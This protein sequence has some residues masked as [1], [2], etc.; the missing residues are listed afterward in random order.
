MPEVSS[1]RSDPQY[2]NKRK[3]LEGHSLGQRMRRK[4]S[5]FSG[6][7]KLKLLG[8]D[9]K[10]RS[11]RSGKEDRLSAKKLVGIYIVFLMYNLL[12]IIM[13]NDSDALEPI[14]KVGAILTLDFLIN[15]PIPASGSGSY[16][17]GNS[18]TFFFITCG[19]L[20]SIDK[21]R[22]KVFSRW[23]GQVFFYLGVFT[24]VYLLASIVHTN[25]IY[26]IPFLLIL[27]TLW[28]IFQS[29][30]YYTS[31]RGFSTKIET[32]LV[33]RYSKFR[34]FLAFL[35]PMI[36]VGIILFMS[37]SYRFGWV[38]LALDITSTINPSQSVEFYRLLMNRVIPA[39]YIIVILITLFLVLVFILS[40]KRAETRSTGIWDN[41]T[42]A[43]MSFFLFIWMIFMVTVYLLL[44]PQSQGLWK[45]LFL[46][47]EGETGNTGFAI[48]LVEFAVSMVFL[49]WIIKDIGKTF[50]WRVF[51]LQKDGL[52]F[53]LLAIIMGQSVSRYAIINQIEPEYTGV[54]IID[55]I[56]GYDRLIIP[57]FLIILLGITVLIYYL[58]PQ[59]MSMFMRREKEAVEEE[60]R[61]M[62]LVLKFLRREFIRKGKKFRV[63]SID[64]RLSELLNLPLSVVHSLITRITGEY[65]DIILEEETTEEGRV[66]YIDFVPITERYQDSEQAEKKA[67][68]L[69]TQQLAG[70]LQAKSGERQKILVK[71]RKDVG[72]QKDAR[73]SGLISGLQ[74][75][76][77]RQA[78]QR[79]EMVRS[80]KTVD[81][82]KD[83]KEDIPEILFT[84][85]R[86]E[87]IYRVK[88]HAM[89]PTP[90][91][92]ILDI[93]S[94]VEEITRIN[95]A[96]LQAT[97]EVLTLQNP[98]IVLV[99]NPTEPENKI[100]E[101]HPI[102]DLEL[103]DIIEEFYPELLQQVRHH[104]WNAL[105]VAVHVKRN[106][107]LEPIEK[108]EEPYNPAIKQLLRNLQQMW[109][110]LKHPRFTK[111]DMGK[112]YTIV[113]KL[114]PK[115]ATGWKEYVATGRA[116]IEPESSVSQK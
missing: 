3:R 57:M 2:R 61:A 73:A 13:A 104:L 24:G 40:M 46:S 93:A 98:N 41:F 42:F 76:F 89:F 39:L 26:M 82:R 7:A 111:P 45:S 86:N 50:G 1:P 15:S 94:K 52:V 115:Q 32:R 106:K 62:Q 14:Q 107:T 58:R 17:F 112:L 30:W 43:L 95:P 11:I 99:P 49:Y 65:V 25:G 110:D 69:L 97:V 87:F 100:I 63:D 88:S 23:Y 90:S 27:S 85:L 4:I 12:Y 34:T 28:L 71:T 48:L 103:S 80:G 55:F 22:N 75:S 84:F 56:L 31:S 83:A 19:I 109:M 9:E 60:D 16:V 20:L 51:F 59:K 37:W 91:M 114:T 33:E 54:N 113:G 116:R 101:F 5:D 78:R 36:I 92:K 96:E 70:S 35:V 44:A 10:G 64:Q 53:I 18:L 105:K 21:V 102:T 66:K 67:Q 74:S 8:R 79:K 38:T 47:G 29:M 6:K 68:H 81:F 77:S 108:L 72:K